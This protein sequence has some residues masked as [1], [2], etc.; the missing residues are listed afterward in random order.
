MRPLY[1]D[2]RNAGAALADA[3]AD[4]RD[5][6]VLVLGLPRG[7]VP[8]AYEVAKALG[9][10]LDV[11]V[12][13]KLGVPSHP[14]YGFGAIASGGIRV[15]D[16]SVVRDLG[17]S[18]ASIAQVESRER[19]ELLRREERYR[20]GRGPPR[21]EGRTV[22]VVDDGIATGGTAKAALRALRDMRPARLLFAAPV[23]PV[24]AHEELITGA[25][26][27]LILATPDDF[28]AVGL[29]Y[30]RFEETSDE[31]V[32][33]LLERAQRQGESAVQLPVAAGSIHGTLVTPAEPL[34]L[35]IFAHGSG[36]SRMSPRNR[37]V[38]RT[39]QD[40]GFATLLLDLLT[41]QEDAIDARTREY[42]FDIDLL[43]RRIADAVGWARREPGSAGLRVGLFGSSTGAAAALVAA[44]LDPDGVQAVVSRGG[45]PDLA[46]RAL[47]H[48]AA[49]TL[50]LVG[51]RDDLV[52][53]L[54]EQALAAMN[55]P[56]ELS[57]VQGAGHLFEEPGTLAEVAG[58]AA[59]FF[60]KHLG[61]PQEARGLLRTRRP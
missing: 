28:R 11:L 46:G 42:R 14:E 29:W 48:V 61:Q 19:A 26:E 55:A 59:D 24:G 54:N 38:A 58:Q 5:E 8:V 44:S 23:G 33:H 56:V 31:E 2:R 43:A 41:E 27:V 36:S 17:L 4:Y 35:V 20:A 47:P 53:Q 32:L 40:R 21:V 13:R 51:S 12:V 22:I 30:E 37:A 57:I 10:D 1:R 25:D 39:L 9:A 6:D 16:E 49:P 15:M 45:R 34:G 60:A 50:L 7:G 3:L 18:D 52:I